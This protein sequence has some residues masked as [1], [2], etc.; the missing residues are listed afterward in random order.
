MSSQV[1]RRPKFMPSNCNSISHHAVQQLF[2]PQS[3][4]PGFS[5]LVDVQVQ[6]DGVVQ[7]QVSWMG[8]AGKAWCAWSPC[9]YCCMLR[10]P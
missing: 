2:G 8:P 6:L 1:H 9:A 4:R 7:E 10:Y 5:R 3:Q